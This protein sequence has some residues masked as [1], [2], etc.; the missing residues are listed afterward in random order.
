MIKNILLGR[1]FLVVFNLTRRCNSICPMCSIWKTPSK[2]KEELTLEEIESIF[3]DLKS[4][5][6]KHV[7]IQG[8]EP[9]LRKDIL[10]IIETLINIGLNPTL[11]TNGLLLNE[12]IASKIA[13]LK[14]NVSISLDSLDEKKYKKIRGVDK[15]PLLLNNIEQCGKIKNKKGMWHIISTISKIN[16]DEVIAL[17]NFSKNNGFKFNAYP[18]NYSHCHSS[19][20]D[21][22]MS[23]DDNPKIIIDAFKKL[24]LLSKKEGL[25]F[26]KLIYDESIKYLEGNY[27]APC[28]AMKKS[29]ILTEKGEIAP[30][31]EFKPSTS[32]KEMGIKQ[33]LK[34]MDY[35][36][37]K[38]CYMETPC[39]Y[40]C[41]RGSGIII[42]KI[43]EIF[44]FTLKHPKVV[45]SYI[46]AYYF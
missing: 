24:S 12:E 4:Y 22:E 30:C 36:I 15:L 27:C 2:L 11:I 31:L 13:K 1:P 19:A 44:L 14:C 8:G 37:V 16:Y 45:V 34:E 39:F 43:P 26:D 25:I 33:A 42:R 6:A 41:T 17:F 46:K 40:G 32:L 23:Y 28:D 20:Y 7:F 35:S 3:K 5:G 38:K 9:L 18:Y 10:Q 29:I 21:E